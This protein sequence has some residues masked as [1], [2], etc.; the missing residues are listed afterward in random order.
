[1]LSATSSDGST[2]AASLAVSAALLT[3][4]LNITSP[5]GPIDSYFWDGAANGA[6]AGLQPW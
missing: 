4:L 6:Q 3:V 5:N 1:M 2:G